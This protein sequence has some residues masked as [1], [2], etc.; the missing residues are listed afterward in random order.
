MK[1]APSAKAKEELKFEFRQNAVLYVVEFESGFGWLPL[2]L[3]F[4]FRPQAEE[5]MRVAMVENPSES[6]RIQTYYRAEWE[7][8]LAL[9]T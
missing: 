9:A 5:Q 6:F 1:K 4:T 7:E 3:C 8:D 2:R